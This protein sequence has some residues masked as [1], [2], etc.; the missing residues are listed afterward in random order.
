MVTSINI[1]S[2]LDSPILAWMQTR[3]LTSM[4]NTVL[5]LP[6]PWLLR[7]ISGQLSL[8]PAI[9]SLAVADHNL[10]KKPSGP[11]WSLM[12]GEKKLPILPVLPTGSRKTY[13]HRVPFLISTLCIQ[14][15]KWGLA[16]TRWR[17]STIKVNNLHIFYTKKLQKQSHSVSY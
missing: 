3:R 9:M 4:P 2:V 8:T 17:L 16:A 11:M 5:Q 14:F 12:V 7:D 15:S 6:H 1:Q 13:E 10:W